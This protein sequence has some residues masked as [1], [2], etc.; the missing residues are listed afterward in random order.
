MDFELL[1]D[2]TYEWGSSETFHKYGYG[3]ENEKSIAIRARNPYDGTLKKTELY[4]TIETL[5]EGNAL[6]KTWDQ[7]VVN[8]Q[9]SIPDRI[10]IVQVE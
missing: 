8:A 9:N 5:V 10:R 2:Y 6:I 3:G 4:F 1:T 7:N